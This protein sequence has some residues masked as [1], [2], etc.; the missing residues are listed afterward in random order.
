MFFL[1]LLIKKIIHFVLHAFWVFPVKRNRITL[2]NDMSYTY[3]DSMKY[4]NKYIEKNYRN[5]YEVIFPVK[6]KNA[7]VES[8]CIFV[9]KIL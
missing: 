4:I 1:H 2:L 9:K 8:N 5:K 6:D 7:T 3:G